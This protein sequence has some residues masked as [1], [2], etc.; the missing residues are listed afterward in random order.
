GQPRV[1]HLLTVLG[2]RRAAPR[3]P[4]SWRQISATVRYRALASRGGGSLGWVRGLAGIGHH[5]LG[6]RHPLADD[7]NQHADGRQV[8]CRRCL[9]QQNRQLLNRVFRQVTAA[10][11][12][13]GRAHTVS[14]TTHP[15]PWGWVSE[16]QGQK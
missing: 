11:D 6:R 9:E 2:L 8:T 16:L 1:I 13:W 4:G 5:L 7:P 15:K 12:R 10:G 3:L 14:M